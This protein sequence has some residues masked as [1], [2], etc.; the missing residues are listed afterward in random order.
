[1]N[2][3]WSL[4]LKKILCLNSQRLLLCYELVPFFF[5]LIFF[6]VALEILHLV[7]SSFVRLISFSV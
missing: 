1:M 7:F 2:T 5:F 6:Y 4:T 3:T